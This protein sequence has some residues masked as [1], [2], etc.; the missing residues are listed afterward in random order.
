LQND[1]L[2]RKKLCVKK[3]PGIING[4]EALSNFLSVKQ[5]ARTNT[6]AHAD[7]LA[8]FSSVGNAF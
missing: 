1:Y 7:R 3:P 4:F 5:L 8:L 6:W 2:E